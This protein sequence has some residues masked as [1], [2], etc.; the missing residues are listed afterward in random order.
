MHQRTSVTP[1]KID[2]YLCGDGQPLLLI[3]GPCV[4]QSFELAMEIADAAG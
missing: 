3:A 4:L 2:R 1:V